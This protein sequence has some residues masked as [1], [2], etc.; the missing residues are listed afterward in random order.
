MLQR[1]QREKGVDIF[2]GAEF[3]CAGPFSYPLCESNMH[4][5][6]EAERAL[7]RAWKNTVKGSISKLPLRFAS[8]GF[9]DNVVERYFAELDEPTRYIVTPMYFTWSRKL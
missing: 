5:A 4:E 3:W 9:T 1:G 2:I 7:G 8:L 6:D